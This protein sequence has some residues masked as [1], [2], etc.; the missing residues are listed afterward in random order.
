MKFH[1]ETINERPV[2]VFDDETSPVNWLL[3]T[4]LEE[5]RTAIQDFLDEIERGREGDGK[6]TGYTGN[7]IDVEFY[8]DRAVIEE[9]W[10]AAGDDDEPAKVEISLDQARQ[11]LLDWRLA[12]KHWSSTAP[13][14]K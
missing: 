1:I 10:P 12:L 3:S 4:F 7:G 8:P 6:P 14:K 11:L 5:A 13:R 2:A 9:L